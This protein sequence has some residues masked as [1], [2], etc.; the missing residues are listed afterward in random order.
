MKKTLGGQLAILFV[1][2]ILGLALA[3]QFKNVQNV[4]GSVSLQRTQELS[5]EI[6][7]LNQD[8]A[9]QQQIIGDLEQMLHEYESASQDDGDFNDTMYR[10]LERSRVLAGLTDLEGA[11]II[12]TVDVVP[13]TG[14]Y[15]E[16][17]IIRNVYH[18]DLLLL[19]NE[20]NAAGAEAIAINDER[21]LSTTEIRNAGNYIVINTNRHST[22]FKIKAIGNPDT[23]EAS[24]KL[25]GGVADTL[26]EEL[27]IK[28]QREDRLKLSKFNGYMQFKYATPIH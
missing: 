19:V 24:L 5:S 22:P 14:W 4:G 9:G 1:S 25:L 15:D 26:G 8:I 12:V 16:S 11:G 3:S 17:T 7:K 10:E 28:I 6:Q 21:I 20:L 2:L 13:I 23:L 27:E 18:D